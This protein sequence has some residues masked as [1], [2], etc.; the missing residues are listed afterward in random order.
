MYSDAGPSDELMHY[1]VIGMKWGVRRTRDAV[2]FADKEDYRQ[3]KSILRD[4]KRSGQITR[5]QYKRGKL[6]NKLRLKMAKKLN[7]QGTK[8]T[9]KA[10]KADMKANKARYKDRKA[11]DL[12]KTGFNMLDKERP[13]ASDYYKAYRKSQ[14][15]NSAF[16]M[17]GGAAT[18][19]NQVDRMMDYSSKNKSRLTKEAYKM[20]GASAPKSTRLTGKEESDAWKQIAKYYEAR[21]K[22]KR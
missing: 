12:V 20:S 4:M 7:K 15:A 21:E 2:N 16:G 11:R 10:L 13:G 8:D 14:Y 19:G 3:R 17:L 9:I 6:E 5:E 22:N 1:G 18:I